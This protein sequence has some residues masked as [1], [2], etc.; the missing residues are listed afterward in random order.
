MGPAASQ[1]AAANQARHQRTEEKVRDVA[2]AS[3]NSGAAEDRSPTSPSHPAPGSPAP[4]FTTTPPPATSSPLPSPEPRPAP[5]RHGSTATPRRA[6]WQQRALNAEQALKAAH[7]EIRGQRARIGELLGQLRDA[8]DDHD[9]GAAERLAT[10]NGTLRQRTGD[11]TA[12]HR[13]LEER[14]RAARS[15]NRFLDKRIAGLEAQLLAAEPGT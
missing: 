11:L 15:N 14:L 8:Q 13:T 7:V 4:S 9:A 2:D 6:A 10:E 5:G 3:A 1:T 12:G